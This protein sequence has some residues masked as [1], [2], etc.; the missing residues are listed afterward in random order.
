[1]RKV[2]FAAVTVVALVMRSWACPSPENIEGVAFTSGE[3][4]NLSKLMEMGEE[5]VNYFKDGAAPAV[6]IRYRSHYD[7]RAMVFVGNYGLSYQQGI[8][9]AC[10]GVILPLPDTADEYAP[11]DTAAFNF[12]AAVKMELEWLVYCDVLSLSDDMIARIDST[13]TSIMEI[14]FAR[15]GVARNG[16]MQYWTHATSVLGY[17]SWY[18]YDST[19]GTWAGIGAGVNGVDGVE[20]VK[21]VYGLRGCSVINPGV[22]IP[23]EGLETTAIAAK[24]HAKTGRMQSLV[25]RHLGDGG[26]VAFL[27]RPMNSGATLVVIDCKGAAVCKKHVHAGMKSIYIRGLAR[28]HYNVRLMR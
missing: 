19:T 9:M 20:G 2:L 23:P 15:T 12:N 21:G 11:I 17:N 18:D 3:T 8:R 22:G 25:V 10:M 16:G 14:S 7:S 4:I 24:K 1:M 13:F 28:G 27:P 26:L 6:G 5:N